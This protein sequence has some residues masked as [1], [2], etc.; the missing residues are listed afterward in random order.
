[1]VDNGLL[2]TEEGGSVEVDDGGEG[3]DAIFGLP[4]NRLA[5]IGH[6]LKKRAAL[7]WGTPTYPLP[8]IQGKTMETFTSHCSIPCH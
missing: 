3:H 5:S 7:S 4:I 8:P 1:M 6:N 2:V